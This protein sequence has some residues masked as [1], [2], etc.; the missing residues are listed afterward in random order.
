[1]AIKYYTFQEFK[2]P[3]RRKKRMHAAACAATAPPS[4][5]GAPLPQAIRTFAIWRDL[6][7]KY[8]FIYF[9]LNDLISSKLCMLP[10]YLLR[11][12]IA[13]PELPTVLQLSVAE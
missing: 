3:R 12:Q 5:P 9:C 6:L 7:A 11:L 1:M 13:P 10:M 4:S 2:K 8:V